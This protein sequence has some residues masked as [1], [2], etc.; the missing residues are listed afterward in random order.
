MKHSIILVIILLSPGLANGHHNSEATYDLD[1]STTV[2]GVVVEFRFANPHARVY[3]NVVASGGGLVRW[4]AEGANPM[5]LR[6]RGWTGDE[7]KAG[8]RVRVTGAPA[9]DGS[10]MIEWHAITLTNGTELEGGNG[11]PAERERLLE[12]LERQ[13]GGRDWTTE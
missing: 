13:R 2:E 9:R 11:L 1:K 7:M 3:F 12:E 10:P 4:M 5:V 6:R 8:D